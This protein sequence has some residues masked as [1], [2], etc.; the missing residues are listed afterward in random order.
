ME[1]IC[2]RAY[3]RW[4]ATINKVAPGTLEYSPDASIFVEL[5]CDGELFGCF[6]NGQS[7]N[8]EPA[9]I[10]DTESPEEWAASIGLPRLTEGDVLLG[11]LL[12]VDSARLARHLEQGGSV[13]E[14]DGQQHE[15]AIQTVEGWAQELGMDTQ[16]LKQKL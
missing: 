16:R 13:E 7:I 1:E 11:E 3:G 8:S 10:E 6:D 5:R 9:A 4:T 15:R 14:W 2:R 12:A